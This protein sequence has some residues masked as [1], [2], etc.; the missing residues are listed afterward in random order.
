MLPP[1][2]PAGVHALVSHD[3]AEEG[4]R[5]PDVIST[6]PGDA[7][8]V[9][10]TDNKDAAV[11]ALDS[12]LE[13]NIE[14]GRGEGKG[15]GALILLPGQLIS[16][17]QLGASD[18]EE[19]VRVD[20]SALV[21]GNFARSFETS[22]SIRSVCSLPSSDGEDELLHDHAASFDLDVIALKRGVRRLL[23]T[24]RTLLFE[25][26]QVWISCRSICYG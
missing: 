9:A 10:S 2:P 15:K 20:K 18:E 23:R 11:N 7:A 22:Q 21:S 3:N 26:L 5:V 4:Q 8:A 25:A 24:H 19:I 6:A 14:V 13:S 1:A 17:D 12:D 16:G